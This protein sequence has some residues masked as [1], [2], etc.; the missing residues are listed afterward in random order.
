MAASDGIIT[1]LGVNASAQCV[2]Y[3]YRNGTSV[4]VSSNQG[5]TANETTI[6]FPVKSGETWQV[7]SGGFTCT[8]RRLSFIP[9][10]SSGG[11]IWNI[12]GSTINYLTGNVG[13]GTTSPQTSLEVSGSAKFNGT[14]TLPSS[15]SVVS[16]FS[17][18]TITSSSW[19]LIS[20]GGTNMQVTITT[21]GRPVMLVLNCNFNPVAANDWGSVTIYRGAT[22]LS[23][24]AT[25]GL[26]IAQSGGASWN[27][28]ISVTWIDIPAA[29]TYTYSAY[30][31]SLGAKTLMGLR[32]AR[33]RVFKRNS[34]GSGAYIWD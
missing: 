20:P 22:D 29:G 25:Q 13:I 21:H 19:T 24:G 14:T 30:G 12:S 33:K 17:S 9:A 32:W 1:A 16:T 5:A 10:N 28:P 8:S 18:Q 27:I 15:Y 23:N 7:T 34:I 4:A 31:R 2:V 6:T 11:N 3:G 26:Q